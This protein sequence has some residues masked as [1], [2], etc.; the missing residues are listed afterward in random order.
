MILLNLLF[1]I[2]LILFFYQGNYQVYKILM[3]LILIEK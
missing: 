2:C 3:L 1:Y